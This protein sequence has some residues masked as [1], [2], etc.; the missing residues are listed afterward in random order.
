VPNLKRYYDG[1]STSD[2]TKEHTLTISI[3]YLR[4]VNV[5]SSG[6]ANMNLYL[7]GCLAYRIWA[8]HGCALPMTF[9]FFFP[10]MF[11]YG[12]Q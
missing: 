1:T 2:P 8:L 7:R 6:V 4:I 5:F 12:F 10:L 11:S 3:E 9:N